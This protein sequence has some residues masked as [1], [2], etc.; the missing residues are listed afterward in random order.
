[1]SGPRRSASA[2]LV[3]GPSGAEG[4]AARGLR[5]HRLHDEVGRVPL[6][7]GEAGLGQVPPRRAPSRRGRARPW[8][9]A[10]PAAGS[11][12]APAPARRCAPA[13]SHT[14]RALRSVS[15][16]GTLPATAVMPRTRSSGEARAKEDRHPRRP[17]PGSVSMTMR[18]G[19]MAD[20]FH[21]PAA[22]RKA[23][24]PASCVSRRSSPPAPARSASARRLPE[25]LQRDVVGRDLAPAP[26][27]LGRLASR[28][29]R[30]LVERPRRRSPAP[31]A[32]PG[33]P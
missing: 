17:W 24:R 5:P 26:H 8:S 7:E 20:A 33:T 31:R 23:P 25:L 10:A 32:R 21:A 11:H 28:R 6:R 15:A 18:R 27:Q 13:T 12:P 1:M 19:S 4:D 14:A 9:G 30:V 2:T 22:E 3:S 16:S 29:H